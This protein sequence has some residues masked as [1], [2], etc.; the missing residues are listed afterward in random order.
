L[1]RNGRNLVGRGGREDRGRNRGRSLR[2]HSRCLVGRGS[3]RRSLSW[4]WR[5]GF[6]CHGLCRWSERILVLGR[7]GEDC[8][9]GGFIVGCRS[10]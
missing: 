8:H 6:R 9:R 4:C 1:R 10:G 2:R 5:A 3:R 7:G